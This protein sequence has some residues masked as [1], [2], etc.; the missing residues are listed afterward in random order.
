MVF[1]CQGAA[2]I[3]VHLMHDGTDQCGV[4][5]KMMLLR[6]IRSSWLRY[7]SSFL[8]NIICFAFKILSVGL[9]QADSLTPP[10]RPRTVST[11]YER[12]RS[13]MSR[14]IVRSLTENS[15]AKCDTESYRLVTITAKIAA[16]LSVGFSHAHSFLFGMR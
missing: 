12:V 10:R 1:I 5:C 11:G 13:M 7:G 14:R 15:A 6:T 2:L 9:N 16:L 8:S 3:Y 4:N